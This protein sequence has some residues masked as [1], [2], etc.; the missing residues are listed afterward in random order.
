MGFFVFILDFLCKFIYNTISNSKLVKD[1][2]M[3]E[4]R[5]AVVIGRFSPV[6][7]GHLAL[8]Q[9]AVSV[10][11][12]V[13]VLVG[14]SNKAPD[15]KDPFPFDLRKKLIL[16]T[17]SM[18]DRSNVDKTQFVN[19]EPLADIP[20]NDE[21]W[22]EQVQKVVEKY[23]FAGHNTTITLVGFKKDDSSYYLDLFPQWKYSEAT[24]TLDLNATQI[25]EELFKEGTITKSLQ[26]KLPKE[27]H[28]SLRG[29]LVQKTFNDLLLEYD[30][31]YDYKKSWEA[32]PYPPTFHTADAVVVQQGHV[33]LI[34]RKDLPGKG[35][36]ALPGGFINENEYIL[37]AA[38]RELKEETKLKVP[39]PVLK[40]SIVSRKVFDKPSRSLRGRVITTA[41]LIHLTNYDNGLPKANG[42]SDAKKAEWIPLAD[43][44]PEQFFEDHYHII[45]DMVGRLR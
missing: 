11:D 14:S 10:A 26:S 43:L 31:I 36:L 4:F 5:L 34:T 39:E 15:I 21:H 23:K 41:F 7:N 44:K 33:L 18:L 13:L 1:F 32:S 6:H 19:V 3:R 16:Q 30:Y 42:S 28:Q 9:K 17:F 24:Q 45:Q 20:Y 38:I 40:G 27:T 8:F 2:H 12:E 29:F 25:R 35:L 22:V 37:N